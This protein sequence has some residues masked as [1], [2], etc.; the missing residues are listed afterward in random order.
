MS[1]YQTYYFTEEEIENVNNNLI[2]ISN[3]IKQ[4]DDKLNDTKNKPLSPIEITKI[5]NNISRLN[6]SKTCIKYYY[7]L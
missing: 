2:I 4:F 7:G 3:K 5:L 1:Y 6:M